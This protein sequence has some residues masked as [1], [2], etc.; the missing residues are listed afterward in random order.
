M[1]SILEKMPLLGYYHFSSKDKTQ[2]YYV[3]QV[4]H[5]EYDENKNIKKGILINIFVGEDLYNIIGQF[6]IG[7]ALDIKVIPNLNTGKVNY[8]III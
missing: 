6:D 8:D 1:N 7:T 3:V 4:L 5:T 2:S